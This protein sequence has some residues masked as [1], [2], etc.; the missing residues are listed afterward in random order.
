MLQSYYG[1]HLLFSGQGEWE[2]VYGS[3]GVPDEEYDDGRYDEDQQEDGNPQGLLLIGGLQLTLNSLSE[4]KTT[5][6]KGDDF[7]IMIIE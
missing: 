2:D 5:R 1:G 6:S 7:T 4:N 3:R